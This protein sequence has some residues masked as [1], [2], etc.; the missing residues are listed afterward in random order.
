LK[1]ESTGMSKTIADNAKI[2]YQNKRGI[3]LLNNPRYNKGTAFTAEEKDEL[4][5]RGLLGASRVGDESPFAYPFS[6]KSFS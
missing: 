5:L 6:G 1:K 2:S 4:G 3:D